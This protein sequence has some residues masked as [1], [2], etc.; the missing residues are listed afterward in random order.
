MRTL[1]LTRGLALAVLLAAL[2][3]CTAPAA[4]A[5]RA[6]GDVLL[7]RLERA[8]IAHVSP[9]TSSGESLGA[10]GTHFRLL[11]VEQPEQVTLRQPLTLLQYAA[12]NTTLDGLIYDSEGR[13]PTSTGDLRVSPGASLALLDSGGEKTSTRA[14]LTYTQHTRLGTYLSFGV[15]L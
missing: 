12:A 4:L 11:P 9:L 14:G 8:S 2:L 15:E 10:R 6:E 7:P 5:E 13:L 1:S 3:V